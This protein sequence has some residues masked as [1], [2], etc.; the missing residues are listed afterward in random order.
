M[1]HRV[2]QIKSRDIVNQVISHTESQSMCPLICHTAQQ[3]M[4]ADFKTAITHKATLYSRAVG[5]INKQQTFNLSQHHHK[6][7]STCI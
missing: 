5:T 3:T 2:L 7:L 6:L 4:H 1:P